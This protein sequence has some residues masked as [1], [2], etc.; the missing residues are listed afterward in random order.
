MQWRSEVF[1]PYYMSTSCSWIP[2]IW[3]SKCLKHALYNSKCSLWS[4]VIV[5]S[6]PITICSNLDKGSRLSTG[7]RY[8]TVTKFPVAIPLGSAWSPSYLRLTSAATS[9][10]WWPPPSSLALHI[11]YSSFTLFTPIFYNVVALI[12]LWGF[13]TY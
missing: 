11:Q 5:S 12:S 7:N 4:C 1:E 10:C 3:L 13:T 2:S 8:G 6:H 9:T